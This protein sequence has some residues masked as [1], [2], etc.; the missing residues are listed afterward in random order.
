MVTALIVARAVQIAASI[1][2]AGIFT[3][4]FITLGL[5]GRSE[6]DDLREIERSLLRLAVWTLIAALVSAVLWFWLEVASMS[7]LSLKDTFSVISVGDG[8]A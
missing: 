3:F 7:G 1:L 4:D 8:F 5:T 2:I 6:S